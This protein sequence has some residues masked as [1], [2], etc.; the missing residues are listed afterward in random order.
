M[1]GFQAG[2]RP[3]EGRLATEQAIGD[4]LCHRIARCDQTPDPAFYAC[5]LTDRPNTW[6]RRTA[7]GIHHHATAFTDGKTSRAAQ[8]VPRPDTGGEDDDVG[9]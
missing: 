3:R 1:Q 9:R 2:A 6:L 8:L 5:H 7:A 4:H